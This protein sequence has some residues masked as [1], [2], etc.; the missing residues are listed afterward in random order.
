[1]NSDFILSKWERLGWD[2]LASNVYHRFNFL[3]QRVHI[4]LT[5]F[6]I[7]SVNIV[8]T[9]DY[10]AFITLCKLSNFFRSPSLF[11]FFSPSHEV[12]ENAIL[13]HCTKRL[14]DV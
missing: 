6:I 14:T 5:H 2:C 13:S 1:M 3:S 8:L 12:T 9:P 10:I 11:L 7:I 4:N